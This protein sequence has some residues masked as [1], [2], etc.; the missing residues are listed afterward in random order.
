MGLQKRGAGAPVLGGSQQTTA[1][2]QP[3]LLQ[4]GPR[5]QGAAEAPLTTWAAQ[6]GQRGQPGTSLV[7]T[8]RTLE[9]LTTSVITGARG[10]K[11][12]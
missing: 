3:A 2:P 11:T 12:S 9:K 5:L 10:G 8:V 4:G 6:A 7:P 1:P